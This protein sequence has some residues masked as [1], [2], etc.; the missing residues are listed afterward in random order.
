[1][2]GFFEE[3]GIDVN[4]EELNKP[5]QVNT[6]G[7]LLAPGVYKMTI[8]KVYAT[9][10]DSGAVRLNAELKFKREDGSEGTF[11]WNTYVKSGD[12]KG[13]KATYTDKNGKEVPLPGVIEMRHFFKA[14][15]V[16]NP[17]IKDA[18]IEV[19]GEQTPV[20]ALPEL[21]GKV[22]TVGVRHQYDD[23]RE[24]DVAFVDTFLDKD[25][26]N[27]DGEFLEDKLKEKIEKSPFKEGK[28]KKKE[29]PKQEQTNLEAN[30]WA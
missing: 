7:G 1:M 19:F 23:Y 10:A 29:E 9:K 30:P 8:D 18:V 21:T 17:E 5:Q 24:K 20:K 16:E 12:A 13:N 27:S 26:K 11:F 6:G 14:A 25:G 22:V 4:N 15:G 3:I 28:K 2:A